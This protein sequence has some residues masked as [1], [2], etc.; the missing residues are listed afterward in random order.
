MVG[1]LYVVVSLA[2]AFYAIPTFWENWVVPLLGDVVGSAAS[3]V[4]LAV[5]MMAAIAGLAFVGVW[6]VG[7]NPVKGLR[8]GIFIGLLGM[9]LIGLVVS[10]LGFFL[11]LKFYTSL[12]SAGSAVLTGRIVCGVLTAL[13]LVLLGWF[14]FGAG[15]Q[16]F[17]V[18]LE[19]QGWFN[20]TAYKR[21]QG[22]NVRAYTIAGILLVAGCGIYTMRTHGSLDTMGPNLSMA[23]PFTGSL[24]IYGGDEGDDTVLNDFR[25]GQEVP[26]LR[27]WFKITARTLDSLDSLV[28]PGSEKEDGAAL[29]KLKSLKNK[30]FRTQDEFSIALK[31]VLT[32]EEFDR[33][34]EAVLRYAA[35]ELDRFALRDQETE[36]KETHVKIL[37]PGDPF[38]QEDHTFQRGQIVK[39]ET[40]DAANEDE[41]VHQGKHSTEAKLSL[42]SP[43]HALYL[44]ITVLPHISY[45]LPLLLGFLAGWIGWRIVNLPAFADFLIATE[46]ELNK[47]SWTTRSRL[48]QDTIVVL[49]T[50]I[51]LAFFLLVADVG[52]SWILR[53]VGVL[54]GG[55]AVAGEKAETRW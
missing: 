14:F 15:F 12:M 11:E 46:A 26:E 17:I 41:T 50:V 48:I 55:Q 28:S 29:S 9:L 36:F 13:L 16:H 21:S 22:R 53:T 27:G 49:V 19:E 5:V 42:P 33:W 47:V 7:P 54:H 37:E 44:Q 39:R 18:R 8:A 32:K 10:V 23:I 51:L 40:F 20:A 34:G 1:T 4:L 45:T 35:L 30:E 2:V 38:V 25:N 43:E 6:L 24:R 31:N 52:W 3:I